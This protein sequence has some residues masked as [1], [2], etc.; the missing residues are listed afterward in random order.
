MA[1]FMWH[2]EKKALRTFFKRHT[3]L[4]FKM[5]T[6]DSL[7]ILPVI[8][9]V[10]AVRLKTRQC[11]A[12]WSQEL[13]FQEGTRTSSMTCRSRCNRSL[14][15]VPGTRVSTRTLLQPRPRCTTSRGEEEGMPCRRRW[16]VCTKQKTRV[17]QSQYVFSKR[18]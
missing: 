13:D 5:C 12:T 1:I 14:P 15:N 2:I 9:L 16:Q 10:T 7:I 4:D 17:R 8:L 6:K 18:L 3:I 11:H